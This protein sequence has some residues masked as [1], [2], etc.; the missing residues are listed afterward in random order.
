MWFKHRAW[1][2][3]AWVLSVVNLG[4][5]L[6]AMRMIPTGPVHAGAHLALAIGLAFG[7]RHLTARRRAGSMDDQL[8]Q[9]LEHNE[10]LQQTIDGM[11]QRL[12]ELEERVDFTERML[13][14]QRDADRLEAPRRDV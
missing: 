7:A 10:Q 1:I 9:T 4:A 3:V 11:Q 2:P 8:Q 6:F 5:A 13:A 14:T 12:Y